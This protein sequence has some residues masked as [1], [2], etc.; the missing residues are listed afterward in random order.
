MDLA[1]KWKQ[2][3]LCKANLDIA[4]DGEGCERNPLLMDTIMQYTHNI[5]YTVS[6][7]NL[8]TCMHEANMLTVCVHLR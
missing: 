8:H 7:A 2:S 3:Q 6:P 4:A 1:K 5:R